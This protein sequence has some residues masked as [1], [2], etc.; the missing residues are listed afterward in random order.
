M[1]H[2]IQSSRIVAFKEWQSEKRQQ[3][4]IQIGRHRHIRQIFQLYAVQIKSNESE[5]FFKIT[6]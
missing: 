6:M 4:I 3:N 5:A 2:D 1:M